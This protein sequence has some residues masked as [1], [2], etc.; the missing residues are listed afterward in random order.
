MICHLDDL[1]LLIFNCVFV[2]VDCVPGIRS[3]AGTAAWIAA[4][5]SLR[6]KGPPAAEAFSGTD[7][8]NYVHLRL[9]RDVSSGTAHRLERAP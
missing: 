7:Q 6:H 3:K 5:L 4:E 8:W 9:P 1:E 2:K